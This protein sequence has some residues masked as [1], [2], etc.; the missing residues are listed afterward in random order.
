MRL[1]IP[2]VEST[3]VDFKKSIKLFDGKADVLELRIDYLNTLTPAQLKNLL[4]LATHSKILVTNRSEEEGG[5]FTGSEQERIDLLQIAVEMG[6]D[7][8][9]V[10]LAVGRAVIEQFVKSARRKTKIIVS[11]HNFECTPPYHIL[12]KVMQK[13]AESG[14]DICKIVTMARSVFDNLTTFKLLEEAHQLRYKLIAISMGQKGQITRV[15]SPLLGGYLTF[16]PGRIEKI[17]APGQLTVAQ[18]QNIWQVMG[19]K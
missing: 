7:Y 11:Y 16:A 10:E 18:L 12:S 1:A 5:K 13:Q 14:A 17:S 8:I 15:I 2:I 19:I 6:V 4:S 9:D 3:L